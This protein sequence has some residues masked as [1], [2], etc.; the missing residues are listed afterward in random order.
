MWW[1][2]RPRLL[3]WRGRF[4]FDALRLSEWRVWACPDHLDVLMGLR[5]FGR[6]R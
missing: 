6:R 2:T 4:A 5:E 3:R 1:A